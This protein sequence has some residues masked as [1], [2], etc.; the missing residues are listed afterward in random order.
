MHQYLSLLSDLL[1]RGTV[2]PDRTGVGTL[3]N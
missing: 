2:K 1:A 3:S